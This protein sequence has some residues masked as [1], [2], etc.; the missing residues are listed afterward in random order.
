MSD[1]VA[2]KMKLTLLPMAAVRSHRIDR[3]QKEVRTSAD[4]M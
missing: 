1:T 3:M 4:A 2:K